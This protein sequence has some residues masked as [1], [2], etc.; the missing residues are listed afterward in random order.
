MP[1]WN[2]LINQ[3]KGEP[4]SLFAVLGLA[5]ILIAL[6]KIKKIEF[7]TKLMSKIAIMLALAT[8]LKMFTIYRLPNGGSV[9]LGSMVPILLLAILYGPEVG[10]LAGFSFGIINLILEPY[11][12]HPVQVLFDYPLAFMALGLAGYIKKSEH[13][14]KILTKII[15]S[16]S[17][18]KKVD[19]LQTIIA[20]II[21]IMGRFICAFIS[22]VVFF[23]SDAPK[24]TSPYV[25]SF[26]YNGSYISLDG[27]ICILILIMLP[28]N[29]IKS[30]IKK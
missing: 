17:S 9:T 25:Y 18:L 5:L 3:I 30:V 11:I 10:I 4:T 12:L 20:A 7:T 15:N 28:L 27:I 24:G 29:Q 1:K 2:N 19:K 13:M 16:P 6:I 8:V 26:L 23:A 21:G 14:K 22:G